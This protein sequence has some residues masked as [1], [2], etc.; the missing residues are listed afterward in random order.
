MSA[1]PP[2]RWPAQSAIAPIAGR[3]TI[4]MLAHPHCPCTRAS[5]A[6]LAVLMNRI[7][8]R[9]NA[10]VLFVRPPHVGED[11]E[12]TDLWRTAARIPGVTVRTDVDGA[13]AKRFAAAT[14][15][16][17]VVYDDDG[18]LVFEGGI[19][20]SRGHEGDNAGLLRIISLVN[21]GRADGDKSPVYGC[22][23]GDRSAESE[24]AQL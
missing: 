1:S 15:G 8:D 7:G 21:R 10:H 4:V 23:L 6:E 12:Q 2:A 16:Q 5:L 13:E 18:R 24:K 19:T 14:S 20:G 17:T 22:P 3:A 9:A 11:W